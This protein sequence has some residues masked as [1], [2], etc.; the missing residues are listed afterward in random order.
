MPFTSPAV[1]EAKLRI[2]MQAVDQMFIRAEETLKHTHYRLRCWL[3]TYHERHFRPVAFDSL[4]SKKSHTD[5]ISMWKHFICYVFRV[6]ATDVRLRETIY[7]VSFRQVEAGQL[8]YIWSTL[9]EDIGAGQSATLAQTF[10]HTTPLSSE[11]ELDEEAETDD[12]DDDSL[13]SAD[14]LDD[15]ET[16]EDDLHGL[17]YGQEQELQEAVSEFDLPSGQGL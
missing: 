7:G 8:R 16:E 12:D 6:W 3:Q 5:Y 2:L 17:H 4:R 13:V 1:N 11:D 15:E 9:L 10:A 14:E